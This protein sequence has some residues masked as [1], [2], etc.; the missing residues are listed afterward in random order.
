M[1]KFF[2]SCVIFLCFS[3]LLCSQ[4]LSLKKESNDGLEIHTYW[5]N[6]RMEI[7]KLEILEKLGEPSNITV[8]PHKTHPDGDLFMWEYDTGIALYY[9]RK[10]ETVSNIFLSNPDFYISIG[11]NKIYCQKTSKSEVED[12][13]GEGYFV[14]KNEKDFSIY[15]YDVQRKDVFYITDGLQFFYDQRG[16]VNSIFIYNLY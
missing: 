7:P 3:T 9:D 10:T 12:M 14:M 13:L 4:E 2:I 6:I 15:E 16:I 5:D 8:F 1:K 11:K